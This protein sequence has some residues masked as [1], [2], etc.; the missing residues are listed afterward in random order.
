M[1]RRKGEPEMSTRCTITVQDAI[2]SYTLYRHSDGYP[3]SEHG[4]LAS[5]ASV[6]PLAWPLPRFEADEFAASIIAAWKKIP[7]GIRMVAAGRDLGVEYH[8]VIRPA[9][10]PGTLEVQV[11]SVDGDEDGNDVHT[12][13]AVRATLSSKGVKVTGEKRKRAA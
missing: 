9:N 11:F 10:V 2:G 6:L 13:C 12:L 3:E 4:V 1:P 5:L 8:Y 7:G